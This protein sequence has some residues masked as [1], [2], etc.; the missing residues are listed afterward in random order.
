M[1]I[2][3]LIL[4]KYT[5][6]LEWGSIIIMNS[7]DFLVEICTCRIVSFLVM[8]ECPKHPFQMGGKE[9]KDC[10]RWGSPEGA[11]WVLH[12]ML[13]KLLKTLLMVNGGGHHHHDHHDH[14]CLI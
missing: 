13:L 14:Q 9:G 5:Y 1:S 7:D 6:I 8:M 2:G 12:Q 10:M 11:Y 3:S 4:N